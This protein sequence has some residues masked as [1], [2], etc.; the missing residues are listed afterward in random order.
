MDIAPDGYVRNLQD[1]ILRARYRNG[2]QHPTL[3]TPGEIYEYKIDLWAT[4]NL[5]LVGHRIALEISSSKFPQFDR[6]TN[7][8]GEAGPDNIVVADQTVYHDRAHP[9]RL[10]LPVIPR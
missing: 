7:A 4:S 1:G 9:T 5:F 8:G 2:Y 6:N 10:T 3:I